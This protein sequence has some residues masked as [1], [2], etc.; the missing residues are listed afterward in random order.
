MMRR[1]K[2]EDLKKINLLEVAPRRMAEWE[3]HE[4]YILVVRPIPKGKGFGRLVNRLLYEMS[5]KRI[6]LDE[7]GSVAWLHMDGQKT[8]GDIADVLRDRFGEAIE[9]AEERLGQLVWVMRREWLV[10][11]SG[12]D[13]D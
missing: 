8:V 6:K 11:Y 2:K 3:E 10:E 12:I 9:P 13:D 1:L 5:S 4:D 7:V